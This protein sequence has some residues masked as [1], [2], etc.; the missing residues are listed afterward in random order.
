[1]EDRRFSRRLRGLPPESE[2][3]TQ[4]RRAR[5]LSFPRTNNRD[6]PTHRESPRALEEGNSPPC[7]D[8]DPPIIEDYFSEPE[9]PP[10]DSETE[11]LL[12]EITNSFN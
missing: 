4:H 9:S 1:M 6:Q 7:D 10:T 3:L 2:G 12:E 5:S 8:F 11:V